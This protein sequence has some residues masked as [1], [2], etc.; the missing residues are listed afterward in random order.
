MFSR[1]LIA[2]ALV[3]APAGAAEP[4]PTFDHPDSHQADRAQVTLDEDNARRFL[5]DFA[6]CVAGRQPRKAAAVLAL[7]YASEEAGTAANRLAQSEMD[8]LGP[9]SG[10]LSF[11]LNASSLEAGMAEYFLANP[12]R[13]AD[14]RRRDPK[15]FAY[16]EPTALESFGECVVAQ[17]SAAVNALVKT[18]VASDQETAG[19]NALATELAGC[20]PEGET[21]ELDRTA[22]R[23]LLA[24]SIYKH[25]AMPPAPVPAPATA[26][27]R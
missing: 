27:E 4:P 24:V 12:E 2:L 18:P 26:P 1:V 13:I 8:C 3:G 22:L 20:I 7:P 10:S 16:A 14:V 21:L 25:F 17:N 15:A 23:Q 5:D 6:R 19:V 9:F 11:S